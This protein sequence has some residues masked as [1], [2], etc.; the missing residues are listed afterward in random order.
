MYGLLNVTILLYIYT[1]TYEWKGYLCWATGKYERKFFLN[2][3]VVFVGL[4][5]VLFTFTL[6]T[7]LI[8][9]IFDYSDKWRA[10]L[11]TITNNKIIR[12][13]TVGTQAS[14]RQGK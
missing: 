4:V 13:N 8:F 12:K 2:S 10:R 6:F 7:N 14:L 3:P 9:N 1:H 5:T 11:K